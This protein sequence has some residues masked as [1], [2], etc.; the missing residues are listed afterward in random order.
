MLY[1][2]IIY[3]D[4]VLMQ[5]RHS[6]TEK[7]VAK[8]EQSFGRVSAELEIPFS[9]QLHKDFSYGYKR[10][11]AIANYIGHGG[12]IQQKQGGMARGAVAHLDF[13]L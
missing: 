12:L 8:D 6:C 1:S 10:G 4:S 5:L 13:W 3:T 2:Y 7:P 9:Y 11:I